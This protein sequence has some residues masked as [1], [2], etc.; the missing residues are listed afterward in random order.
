MN[1]IPNKC[2]YHLIIYGLLYS[3]L[4]YKTEPIHNNQVDVL[5]VLLSDHANRLHPSLF[6]SECHTC[7]KAN[8][9]VSEHG[10]SKLG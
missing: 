4:L 3:L 7:L 5:E 6:S 2:P 10:M 1:R 8:S 9:G